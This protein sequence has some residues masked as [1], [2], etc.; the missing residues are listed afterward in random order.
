MIPMYS[1]MFGL[2]NPLLAIPAC[3]LFIAGMGGAASN[4]PKVGQKMLLI[5]IVMFILSSYFPLADV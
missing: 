5:A 4:R 3:F 2:F 1:I